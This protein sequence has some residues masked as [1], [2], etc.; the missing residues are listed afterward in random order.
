MHFAE[1]N[2]FL[3]W[4]IIVYE[5]IFWHLGAEGHRRP[6]AHL[7]FQG[8]VKRKFLPDLQPGTQ[9]DMIVL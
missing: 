7:Y 5:Y 3:W 9:P 4:F 1:A 6:V 8:I 2:V